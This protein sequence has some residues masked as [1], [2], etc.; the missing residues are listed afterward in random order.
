[1]LDVLSVPGGGKTP[2]SYLSLPKAPILTDF[3]RKMDEA[4]H[5]QL[6]TFVLVVAMVR[7]EV[8]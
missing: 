2:H 3:N 5:T 6:L 8:I 4:H 1:M 7:A